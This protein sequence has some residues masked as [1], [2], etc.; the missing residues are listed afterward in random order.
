MALSF[1]QYTADG[2]TDTF[3]IPFNYLNQSH[4]QVRVDGV[5]DSGVT[6][7]TSATV[8]TST[9][10]TNGAIVDVRRVTPNTSRL[11]DFED[12]SLLS[13]EDLDQSALQNFYVMQELNDNLSGKI[14][15]D[16]DNQWDADNK[17]IK[18]L[19]NGVNPNDAVNV[20]QTTGIVSQANA[21]KDAAETAQSAAE[22]AQDN[23]ESARDD[24]VQAKNDAETAAASIN[25][26]DPSGNGLSYPRQKATED[27]FEYRTP[28]EVRGDINAQEDRGIPDITG[29][30]FK[31]PRVNSGETGFEY[32]EPYELKADIG[33]INPSVRQTTLTGPVDSEG[34]ANFLTTGSG[35]SPQIVGTGVPIMLTF[36]DG[37]DDQGAVDY[38]AKVNYD[39]SVGPIPANNRSFIYGELGIGFGYSLVPPQY[40]TQFDSRKH[41]LLHFEGANGSTTFT[42]EFGNT[43]EAFGDAQISTSDSKFGSSCLSL[44][45]T[46]DYIRCTNIEM[47]GKRWTLETFIKFND[48]TIATIFSAKTGNTLLLNYDTSKLRLWMG[49]GNSWSIASALFGTTVLNTGQWYHLAIE[50]DG[51]TYRVYVDG[52]VDISV[53]SA[54]KIA[55]TR[56]LYVGASSTGASPINAKFDELR[57]SVDTA[58]Y[59]GAFT[60]PTSAF[61][62]DTYWFNLTNWKMHYGSP[63]SWQI[64][65]VLFLGEAETNGSTVTSVTSYAYR[66]FYEGEQGTL[67][68]GLKTT[69]N[70]NL[71]TRL[72]EASLYY[73]CVI[74]E[75][76][77]EAGDRV[78]IPFKGYASVNYSDAL[79]IEDQRILIHLVG[80][81]SALG[82]TLNKNTGAVAGLSFANWKAGYKVRRAF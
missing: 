64:R 62:P 12:G 7:P 8:K 28:T 43:W 17:V 57:L 16:T 77:Y 37:F 60:V 72:V 27:G 78:V 6:F 63:S 40:G 51:T 18:N 19:A 56:E 65:Q 73:E 14:S 42:D 76:G 70:H 54:I 75:A 4:I 50:Y 46:G 58:R 3:N 32:R 67:S 30:A 69:K 29:H 80:A 61:S 79:V 71:G 23:T 2:V 15:L 20:S 74:A 33:A 22:T 10:P 68:S 81:Y 1:V 48:T 36:A 31:I 52:V 35:L 44:D 47:K 55:N 26:P 5:L 41:A 25:M 39:S 11:V 53:T 9:M 24:A 45:G 38:V 59:A 34:R 13:E 66:G 82:A 49:D 21:A